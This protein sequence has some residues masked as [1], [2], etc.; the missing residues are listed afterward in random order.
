MRILVCGLAGF[1]AG[2]LTGIQLKT[3]APCEFCGYRDTDTKELFE[4][5]ELERLLD[6]DDTD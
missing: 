2:L 1:L 3:K 5:E 6:V 4:Q